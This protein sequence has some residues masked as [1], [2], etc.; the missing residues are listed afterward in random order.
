MAT[1]RTDTNR[2][3]KKGTRGLAIKKDTIRDLTPDGN[4]PK[5]GAITPYQPGRVATVTATCAAITPYKTN[6]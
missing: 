3:S 5:G 4:A 2:A 1:T 6:V